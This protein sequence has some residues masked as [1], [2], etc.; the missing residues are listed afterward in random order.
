[1]TVA[2]ANIK[3]FNTIKPKIETIFK[4][5]IERIRN[6]LTFDQYQQFIRIPEQIEKHVD[7]FIA[8]DNVIDEFTQSDIERFIQIMEPPESYS[9]DH[10]YDENLYKQFRPLNT[11]F[12]QPEIIHFMVLFE[13]AKNLARCYAYIQEI[14]NKTYP[15]PSDNH[16]ID[17]INE[18]I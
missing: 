6:R 3:L 13:T 8:L 4:P 14:L 2:L 16:L 15:F 1:M 9:R 12:S 11:H 18:N 10:P 5:C 7:F 17:Y